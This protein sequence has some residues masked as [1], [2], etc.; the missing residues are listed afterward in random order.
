M[1]SDI[2]FSVSVILGAQYHCESIVSRFYLVIYAADNLS[3]HCVRMMLYGNLCC[4]KALIAF[5]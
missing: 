1:S 2:L 5:S 4:G 3:C